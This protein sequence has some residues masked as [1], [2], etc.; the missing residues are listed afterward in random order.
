MNADSVS[1]RSSTH[2][3]MLR[4]ISLLA[5]TTPTCSPNK[6][7]GRREPWHELAKQFS[8]LGEG[9]YFMEVPRAFPVGL[10][11]SGT[12]SHERCETTGR[13]IH[14]A[15]DDIQGKVGLNRGVE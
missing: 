8:T 3:L 10:H 13:F 7:F 4:R 2:G 1:K 9:G 14:H 12:I 11:L 6:F 5:D 15:P